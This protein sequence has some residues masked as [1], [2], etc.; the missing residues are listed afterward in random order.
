MR[1]DEVMHCVGVESFRVG[2]ALVSNMTGMAGDIQSLPR[3]LQWSM[4]IQIDS[5]CPMPRHLSM[6]GP[7]GRRRSSLAS[8][9]PFWALRPFQ[10]S[11]YS[12]VQPHLLQ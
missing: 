2:E 11:K 4:T 9:L 1:R 5:S 6:F 7:V 12:L 10:S 8:S 3:I